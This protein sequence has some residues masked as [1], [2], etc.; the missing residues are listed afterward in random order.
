MAYEGW[1]GLTLGIVHDQEL[2]W[3][4]AYGYANVE[5]KIPSSVNTKYI[6]ASNTKQFTAIAIL[7]LRDE[8]KLDLNDPAEKYIP[9]INDIQ[10][11]FPEAPKITIRHLLTHTSGLP[12]DPPGYYSEENKM[13][14]LEYI[15][16][17][18][19]DLKCI[20]PPGKRCK[21]SNLEYVMLGDIVAVLSGMPY[22]HYIKTH[23]LEPLNMDD[24]LIENDDELLDNMATG[25]GRRMADNKCV[26]YSNFESKSLAP[27]GGLISTLMDIS[28]YVKWQF[29]LRDTDDVEVLKGTTLKEMQSV[30][31][32]DSGWKMAWGYGFILSYKP[33]YNIISHGGTVKGF[34]SDIATLVEHKIGVIC[35]TNAQDVVPHALYPSS[36]ASN[37]IEW[38]I[39]E[40]VSS[41]NK[42]HKTDDPSIQDFSKYEGKFQDVWDDVQ[43]LTRNCELILFNPKS[44]GPLSSIT[45]LKHVEGK[46]FV[47]A[48]GS[49]F[50]WDGELITFNEG[51]NG[52]IVSFTK[53]EGALLKKV[54]KW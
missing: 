31:E 29:R 12:K 21:Y 41:L 17:K 39:P 32:M 40:L 3:T 36:V 45:E 18:L 46:T 14:S 38:I 33:P 43:V 28:A 54:S 42:E 53:G 7:K 30:Q 49:G 9:W 13:P 44:S 34:R 20:F 10:N 27:A 11:P 1:P 5:K 24:S 48:S 2:I 51:V 52:E 23:L 37:M 6:L 15:K 35:L 4:K 50:G 25:Y 19:S 16:E 22:A 26:A 8:G 47:C